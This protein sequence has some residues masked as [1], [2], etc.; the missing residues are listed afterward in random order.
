M[1]HVREEVG[2]GL[3]EVGWHTEERDSRDQQRV[4]GAAVTPDL[5]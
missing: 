4:R 3:R 1:A 5:A 2:R